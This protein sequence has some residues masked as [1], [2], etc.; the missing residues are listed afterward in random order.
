MKKYLLGILLGFCSLLSSCVDVEPFLQDR[1]AP[2]EQPDEQVGIVRGFARVRNVTVWVPE[3]PA[4]AEEIK[5]GLVS[6]SPVELWLLVTADNGLYEAC[7]L[8]QAFKVHQM[9]VFFEA[10]LLNASY[11]NPRIEGVVPISLVEIEED[12]EEDE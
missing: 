1:P 9:E 11:N 7:N 4:T 3:R 6:V 5:N 12:I 10:N 2:C 8:S